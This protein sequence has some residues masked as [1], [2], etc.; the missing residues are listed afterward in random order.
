MFVLAV[1]DQP[2]Q[3]LTTAWITGVQSPAEEKDIS[4]GLCVQTGSDAHTASY[5]MV[6]PFRE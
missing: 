6:G 5:T 2:V 1:V 3:C 4:S